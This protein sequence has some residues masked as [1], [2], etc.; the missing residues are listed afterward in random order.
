MLALACSSIL[1]GALASVPPGEA[2]QHS[3]S[4]ACSGFSRKH[5]GSK[6][7]NVVLER[8]VAELGIALSSHPIVNELPDSI[9][10]SGDVIDS[11]IVPKEVLYVEFVVLRE[12]VLELQ[13]EEVHELIIRWPPLHDAQHLVP[14]EDELLQIVID[15]DGF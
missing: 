8:V 9:I 11:A 7:R 12:V 5:C 4:T 3:F 13:R 15:K 2:T 14:F 1:S 6:A 10:V